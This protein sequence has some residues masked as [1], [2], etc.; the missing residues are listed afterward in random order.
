MAVVSQQKQYITA[1]AGKARGKAC[2]V[3][4]LYL[5]GTIGVAFM[6][7]F[8]VLVPV[9]KDTAT[10]ALTNFFQPFVTVVTEIIAN[11]A[12]FGTVLLS[13]AI[14]L[15]LALL[16]TIMLLT[17]VINVLRSI[18]KLDNLFMKGNRKI[19]YNQSALAMD[20]MAKIFSAT[21]ASLGVIT[22]IIRLFTMEAWSL[23]F[24]ITCGAFLFIH[25]LAGLVGGTVSR[26]ASGDGFEETPRKR[27]SF[28]PFLRNLF[29][30]AAIFGLVYFIDKANAYEQL[31]TW[32]AYVLLNVAKIGEVI[33]LGWTGISVSIV[34]PTLAFLIVLFTVVIIRH[35]VN[36]SEYDVNGTKGKA[37]VRVA[38]FF[39]FLSALA[40]DVILYFSLEEPMDLMAFVMSEL[41]F[42][43]L[44]IAAIALGIFIIECIM[45]KF[46]LLKK[47]YREEK[48]VETAEDDEEETEETA[49]EEPAVTPVTFNA[50]V[51]DFITAPGVY[52]QAN[53][54]P[55]MVMPM[56]Q[57]TEVRPAPAP[58]PAP[59]PAPT[60]VAAP[61]PAPAPAPVPVAAPAPVVT[62]APAPIQ[63]EKQPL[64]EGEKYAREVKAKW[65]SRAYETA[66]TLAP[67]APVTAGVY[68]QVSPK[69][70]D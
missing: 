47:K 14:P 61:A 35:A 6:A 2:F 48:P 10:F 55:V 20:K 60:Y 50:P 32:F 66:P 22:W 26:F 13:N 38:S 17:C 58:T 49:E 64:T 37:T 1:R 62:A 65:I 33:A 7:F 24:Y 27:G 31:F 56:M 52:M 28:S 69:K 25:C 18:A 12:E 11:P 19:G 8:G 59:A 9:D 42:E 39:V 68:E 54:T 63:E 41:V 16:Y 3:G 40:I 43:L 70:A 36:P 53:G 23:A 57:Q 21:F 30:F 67:S 51:L 46:P 44:M 5:L 4:I 34:I 29:Q 15:F 45:G